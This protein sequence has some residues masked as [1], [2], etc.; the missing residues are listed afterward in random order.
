MAYSLMLK[1]DEHGGFLLE[2]KFDMSTSASG[3]VTYVAQAAGNP[4]NTYIKVY[5]PPPPGANK[6]L[7]LDPDDK[8]AVTASGNLLVTTQNK[9]PEILRC[10]PR[11][12]WAAPDQNGY[13]QN[14]E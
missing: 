3:E 1:Y 5:H 2:G 14:H 12:W 11:E 10:D 8:V 7:E 9:N 6:K 13:G 4:T